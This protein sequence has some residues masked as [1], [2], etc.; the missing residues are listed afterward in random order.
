MNI[1]FD[2]DWKKNFGGDRIGSKVGDS[3]MLFSKT[4]VKRIKRKNK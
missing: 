1:E 3:Q 4:H 2:K